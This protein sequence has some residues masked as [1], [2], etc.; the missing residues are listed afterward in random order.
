MKDSL[1]LLRALPFLVCFLTAVPSQ[2]ALRDVFR[3]EALLESSETQVV[4]RPQYGWNDPLIL[5]DRNRNF[6]RDY[7]LDR[8]PARFIV[9]SKPTSV[10]RLKKSYRCSLSA[11][12]IIPPRGLEFSS[13]RQTYY[14]YS[15]DDRQFWLYVLNVEKLKGKKVSFKIYSPSGKKAGDLTLREV[16]NHLSGGN[17]SAYSPKDVANECYPRVLPLQGKGYWRIEVFP[18]DRAK[19]GIW[20][21]GIPNVLSTKDR[22][23][24]PEVKPMRFSYKMFYVYHI[25]NILVR[26]LKR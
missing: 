23:S 25:D 18:F 20:L 19:Y 26:F 5:F 3:G 1:S 11:T 21:E 8:Q 10:L 15:P 6:V 4:C 9:S 24:L 17:F 16:R 2:A 13:A 22:F 12:K 7:Y 14:F